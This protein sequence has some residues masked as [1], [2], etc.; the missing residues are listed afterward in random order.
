[1]IRIFLIILTLFLSMGFT[2]AGDTKK[3][4]LFRTGLDNLL[5]HNLD[6]IRGKEIALVTNQSGV[7]KKGIPNY[8]RLMAIDEVHLK[9]IFSPEH[10]LFGEAAAG[11]KVNYSESLNDLPE[12]ISVKVVAY[13]SA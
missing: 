7:D 11:E 4:N 5:D 10:G 13:K 3:I 2:N 9:R 6:K 12:V 1:M 8:Q